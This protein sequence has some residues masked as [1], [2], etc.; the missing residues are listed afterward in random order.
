MRCCSWFCGA[1]T[2]G[3]YCT[4]DAV[5]PC[6]DVTGECTSLQSYAALYRERVLGFAL[7][8]YTSVNHLNAEVRVAA[9]EF[10]AKVFKDLG[11]GSTKLNK[12]QNRSSR[13]S[14]QVLITITTILCAAVDVRH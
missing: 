8:V 11:E 12:I 9:M 14:R 13:V 1:R 3:E 10:V 7:R 4:I 6:A 2:R 5:E